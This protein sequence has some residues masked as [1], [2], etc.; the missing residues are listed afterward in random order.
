MVIE[1]EH[2]GLLTKEKFQ[3]I[4]DFLDKNAKFIEEK[5]RFS[6]IYFQEKIKKASERKDI[7]NQKL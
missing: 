3:K 1:V 5:D 6:L 7:I 4:K 2:R